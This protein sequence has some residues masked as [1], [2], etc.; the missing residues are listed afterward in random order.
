ME[1]LFVKVRSFNPDEDKAIPYYSYSKIDTFKK[2]P[3]KF[4][5]V[6]KDEKRTDTSD[7]ARDLGTLCHYILELKG[8]MKKEGLEID[9][10]ALEDTF[11]R[12]KIVEDKYKNNDKSS[13]MI[14]GLAT[15]QKKYFDDYI[16]PDKFGNLYSS[17]ASLFINK[18]VHEEMEDPDWIPVATEMPFDFVYDNRAHFHG[19]IDRVDKNVNT[20]EMRVIDYKTSKAIFNLADT[21]TSLQFATY[22][23]A[24]YSIYGVIPIQYIYRFILI[25]KAQ[26]ALTKGWEKRADKKFTALLDQIQECETTGFWKTCPTP[27]CYW[28]DFSTSNPVTNQYSS[29]CLDHSD[30]NPIDKFGKHSDNAVS[31]AVKERGKLIF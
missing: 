4:K 28:C 19:F 18:V 15:L 14:D 16:T 8:N 2:C 11:I 10:P 22:A 5:L 17:K 13:G 23:M 29:E 21:V 3:F 9:Y 20:G 6:Y 26:E 7:L 1:D 30:W 12:G 25:D 27:L 31:K 24:V